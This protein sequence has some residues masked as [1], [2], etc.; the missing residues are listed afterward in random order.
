MPVPE[1]ESSKGAFEST[2]FRVL[3][4]NLI[5]SALSP[6]DTT[7]SPVPEVDISKSWFD[8]YIWN[9]FCRPFDLA[10]ENYFI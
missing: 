7:T 2:V 1:A 6:P 8:G 9:C 3:P 4:S 10:S 5:A